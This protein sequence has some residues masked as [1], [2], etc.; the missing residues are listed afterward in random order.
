QVVVSLWETVKKMTS[1]YSLL[2]RISEEKIST[3]SYQGVTAKIPPRGARRVHGRHASAGAHD[4][5]RASYVGKGSQ[6]Q[7]AH[8]PCGADDPE[9]GARSG[10]R[11]PGLPCFDWETAR[12]T[13]G[14][15]P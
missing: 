14:D 12:E 3:L 4:G 10:S 8:H 1:Y 15:R 5:P 13:T 9:S 11:S 6:V 7:G 2:Q